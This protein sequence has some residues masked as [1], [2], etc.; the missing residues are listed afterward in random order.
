M[1]NLRLGLL[2]A[3]G[4]CCA[5][6]IAPASVAGAAQARGQFAAGPVRAAA[7]DVVLVNAPARSVCTGH[8]FKVGVW[9]QQISGGSR[10]YRISVSGPRHRRFFYQAGRAPSAS[11]RVWKVMAGRAGKYRTVYSAHRRGSRKW[12]TF[13]AITRARRCS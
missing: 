1:R 3:V 8:K 12:T 10:A 11:W 13:L 4:A 5:V 2:A 6:V 9:F 7:P